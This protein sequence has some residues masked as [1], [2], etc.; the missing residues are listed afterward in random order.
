MK[1]LISYC[2]KII[3][4]STDE[5]HDSIAAKIEKILDD[6]KKLATFKNSLPQDLKE[7][8]DQTSLEF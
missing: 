1:D 8:L 3:E 2:E 5:S 4:E 7:D 6:D